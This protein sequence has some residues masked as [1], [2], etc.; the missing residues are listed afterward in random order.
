MGIDFRIKNNNSNKIFYFTHQGLGDLISCSS[1][2]NYI[3]EKYKDHTIYILCDSQKKY[4]TIHNLFKFK[5]VELFIPEKW[6]SKLGC[7]VDGSVKY[8]KKVAKE[9]NASLI[10]SG[11]DRYTNDQK[12]Y[13][14]YSFYESISLNYDIKYEYFFI[15]YDKDKRERS[16]NEIT[17]GIPYIFVH[18][19][20]SRG[21]NINFKNKNSLKVVKNDMNY[22][23]F[24]YIDVIK[25]AK[26]CHMMG[27]SLLC[28]IDFFE[29]DFEN[30][31]YYFYDFRGSNVNFKGKER[32]IQVKLK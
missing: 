10:V 23:V 28:L 21:R 3:C 7:N 24:D 8:I 16:F 29:L 27:S 14:D 1:I 13:W 31:N 5:N 26:E 15:N 2:V 18:D 32:W 6:K 19:D 4:N 25:N 9:N 20:P 22:T 30:C 12:K 17:E 11:C